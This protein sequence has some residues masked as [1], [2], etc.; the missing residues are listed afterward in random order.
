MGGSLRS[1]VVAGALAEPQPGGSDSVAA[2][3]GQEL[4]PGE[5]AVFTGFENS[6][7]K[8]I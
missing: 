2:G 7:V 4:E 3:R 5:G 1:G 8:S 6:P